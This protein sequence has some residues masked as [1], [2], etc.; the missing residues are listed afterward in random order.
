MGHKVK[1]C[2]KPINHLK[3]MGQEGGCSRTLCKYKCE[4]YQNVKSTVNKALNGVL[5]P[6]SELEHMWTWLW[7]QIT[8]QLLSAPHMDAWMIVKDSQ[9]MCSINLVSQG[10]WDDSK[11]VYMHGS[12]WVKPPKVSYILWCLNNNSQ[13]QNGHHS[14]PPK[15]NK[16]D[17]RWWSMNKYASKTMTYWPKRQ[18]LP[19]STCLGRVFKVDIPHA[20]WEG[21]T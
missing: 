1:P 10:R 11:Y 15:W 4:C 20:R 7:L 21:N 6:R 13:C 14:N 19:N 18:H 3:T 8:L 12:M 5:S 16:D 2:A 17:K 9:L